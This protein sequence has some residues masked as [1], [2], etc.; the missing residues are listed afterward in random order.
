MGITNTGESA[1]TNTG[2]SR[3]GITNTGKGVMMNMTNM[4]NMSNITNMTNILKSDLYRFG[5]SKLFYGITA[6]TCVI[7]FLLITLMR[8]D[9]RLGISTFGDITAF[10]KVE[11]VIR[12]GTAYQ[13]GL[14]IFVA[15]L[16]SVFIGQ[17]YQWQTWQHKWIISKNRIF[18][19][20]SKALLSSAVSAAIFLAFQTV[21]LL[22]SGQ[23]RE[24]LILGYAGMILSGAFVYAALGSVVCLLS[25]LVKSSTASIIVCLGYVMFSETLVSVIRNL[26]SFSNTAAR[27][28]EWVVRHSVYGMSSII[29][30]GVSS[31][32]LVINVI[33]NSLVIVLLST[34][35]GLSLFRK[36]EL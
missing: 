24:L 15:A 23:T 11:D 22:G 30:G 14:G 17:E 20:L 28:V 31:A 5:K 34:V 19:Y 21:A 6:F 25:T 29:S 35:I 13:K 7:S 4:T 16:V 9:I 2:E 8:Q 33:I 12:I 27:V 36:Y 10:K 26:A 32:G 18:I 1:I 3:M